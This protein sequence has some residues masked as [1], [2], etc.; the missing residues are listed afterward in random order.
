MCMTGS[1]FPMELAQGFTVDMAPPSDGSGDAFPV[2]TPSLL[3]PTYL[4]AQGRQHL[5]VGATKRTG[6]SPEDALRVRWHLASHFSVRSSVMILQR[7][8]RMTRRYEGCREA[9]CLRCSFNQTLAGMAQACGRPVE[10][11]SDVAEA[12]Q[13]LLPPACEL[14]PPLRRW[15]VMVCFHSRAA[16]PCA[17]SFV[18]IGRIR[19]VQSIC[20]NESIQH[21]QGVRSGVRA[22]PCRTPQGAMPYAGRVD[23]SDPERRCG[24]CARCR[25]DKAWP[26]YCCVARAEPA[27]TRR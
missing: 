6:L 24:R 27:K 11:P 3:G 4:A 2:G 21:I 1:L 5:V 20:L 9:L 12:R 7:K 15:R 18:T 26:G 10:D 17:R 19:A 22:L 14:W 13:A 8:L 16:W 25:Y 23:G